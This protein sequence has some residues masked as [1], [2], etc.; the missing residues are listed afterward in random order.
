MR[1]TK[2]FVSRVSQRAISKSLVELVCWFGERDERNRIILNMKNID[3]QLVEVE[4]LKQDLLKARRKG[5]VY[6]VE[7]TG[8]LITAYYSGRHNGFRRRGK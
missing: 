1:E 2:H 4:K 6:V 3:E 8:A 7:D 5:S